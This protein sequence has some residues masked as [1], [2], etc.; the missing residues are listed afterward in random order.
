MNAEE[1]QQK[2]VELDLSLPTFLILRNIS[3]SPESIRSLS[4]ILG[5]KWVTTLAMVQRMEKAG[6]VSRKKE[7]NKRFHVFVHITPKGFET[8]HHIEP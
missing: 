1:L 4:S 5:Q 7:Q 6:L 8:L 2:L 3:E